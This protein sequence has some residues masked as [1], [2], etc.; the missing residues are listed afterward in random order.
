MRTG[1]EAEHF[2]AGPFAPDAIRLRRWDDAA[3]HWRQV[4]RIRTQEP[5]GYVHLVRVLIE[6]GQIDNARAVLDDLRS[7]EWPPR[8]DAVEKEIRQLEKRLAPRESGS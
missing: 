1:Q 8:F 5:T 6:S 7:R 3:Y 4:I 2:A